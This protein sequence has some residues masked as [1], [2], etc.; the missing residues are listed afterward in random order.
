VPFPGQ[1]YATRPGALVP[2]PNWVGH[3]A[4]LRGA[5]NPLLVYCYARG[6]DQASGVRRQVISQFLADAGQ[7]PAWA[8]WNC[9]DTLF[10]ELYR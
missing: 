8:Q 4:H 6:G 9:D 7:R 2:E 10:S 3:L 1:T 5:D